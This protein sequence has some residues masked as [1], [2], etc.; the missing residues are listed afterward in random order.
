MQAGAVWLID[1]DKDDHDM[2]TDIFKE[3]GMTNEL[4]FLSGAEDAIK[5]LEAAAVAPFMIICDVNLPKM[6]GFKLRDFML[7]NPSKKFHSVP[8]IYWSS[9]ASEK[10]I[11][12]AYELSAHGFFIKETNFKEMKETFLQIISYWQKSKMPSKVN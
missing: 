9:F 8:F 2:V 3:L 1:D 4:V 5:K 6:D 11:S 12:Q 10:Q 7:N